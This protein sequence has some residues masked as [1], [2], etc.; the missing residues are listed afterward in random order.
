MIFIVHVKLVHACGATVT[1]S[2]GVCN[3]KVVSK[4]DATHVQP[5]GGYT[6]GYFKLK[7]PLDNAN[8]IAVCT[9]MG[10]TCHCCREWA[11]LQ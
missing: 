6:M 4:D 1:S 11:L 8:M 7:E 3:C 5:V 2:Q 9:V 10:Y